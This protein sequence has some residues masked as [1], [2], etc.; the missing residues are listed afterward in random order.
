MWEASARDGSRKHHEEGKV[1]VQLVIDSDS[2]V[3]NATIAQ[4]SGFY[5]LDKASLDFAMSL[6]FPAS[7]VSTIKNFDDGQP[8]VAFPIV[9]RL[10]APTVPGVLPLRED[11]LPVE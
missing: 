6:K 1:I 7:T 5:R 4:S 9:W 2:C 10:Y 8:T 3:R 11:G